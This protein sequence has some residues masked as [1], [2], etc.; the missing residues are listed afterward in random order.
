[1]VIDTHAPGFL[2]QI[3]RLELYIT[4][5][6]SSAAGGFRRSSQPRQAALGGSWEWVVRLPFGGAAA[7]LTRHRAYRP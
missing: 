3:G 6:D 5:T 1:M 4:C 7:M 2:V